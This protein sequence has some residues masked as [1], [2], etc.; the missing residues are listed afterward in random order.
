MVSSTHPLHCPFGYGA[1]TTVA[2]T[3]PSAEPR[4]WSVKPVPA[5]GSTGQN[6]VNSVGRFGRLSIRSDTRA[7]AATSVIV[8][9]CLTGLSPNLFTVCSVT[10]S[11]DAAGRVSAE[12]RARRH[13]TTTSTRS[14][15]WLVPSGAACTVTS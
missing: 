6:T 2:R 4:N 3:G 1:M 15:L 14:T 12:V 5:A 13:S 9:W 8:A 7:I 10:V 11:T